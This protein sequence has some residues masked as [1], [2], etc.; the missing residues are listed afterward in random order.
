MAQSKAHK[1]NHR[2][3]ITTQNPKLADNYPKIRENRNT[4]QCHSNRVGRLARL[5]CV[6][7]TAPRFAGARAASAL[8]AG[9]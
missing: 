5:A 6:G 2:I 4:T 9:K 1:T 7:R 8:A 3:T